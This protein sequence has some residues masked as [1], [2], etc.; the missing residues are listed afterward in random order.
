MI[1]ENKEEVVLELNDETAE[2]ALDKELAALPKV[3]KNPSTFFAPTA[4]STQ[5]KEEQEHVAILDM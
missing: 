3:V 4:Q 1:K 2:E 5:E